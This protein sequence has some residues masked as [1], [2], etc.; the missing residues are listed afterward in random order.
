MKRTLTL[1]TVL[2][3]LGGALLA[4]SAARAQCDD[5]DWCERRRPYGDYS[6]TS[7]WGRYGANNPVKDSKEARSRLE[8]FFDGQ[9]VVVRDVTERSSYFEAEIA[10]RDGNLLDRVIIDKRTGRIRSVY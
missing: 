10:G 5:C 1:M 9:E 6:D 4:P 2:A 7:S 8:R 3:V